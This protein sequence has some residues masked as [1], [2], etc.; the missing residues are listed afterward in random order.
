MWSSKAASSRSWRTG[1]S[2]ARVSPPRG[3]PSR[4]P[5]GAQA[6]LRP[7]A[8]RRRAGGAHPCRHLLGKRWAPRRLVLGAVP[9][10]GSPGRGGAS[11]SCRLPG[12][13]GLAGWT[14]P[15]EREGGEER[16]RHGVAWGF[17]LPGPE[18]AGPQWTHLAPTKRF[19]ASSSLSP[20]LDSPFLRLFSPFAP[21]GRPRT[22]VVLRQLRE[23]SVR[24]NHS[25][26]TPSQRTPSPSSGEATSCE[27]PCA[28]RV[29]RSPSRCPGDTGFGAEVRC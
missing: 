5:G 6:D 28:D 25:N 10:D 2:P 9:G 15:E 21:A 18:Q 23:W 24:P 19:P 29:F 14:Q 22:G 4:P 7:Q 20:N 12:G 13:H 11:L 1:A 8:A 27:L 17:P 26:Q 3:G 16:R